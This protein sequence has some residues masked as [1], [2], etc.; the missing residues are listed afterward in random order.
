MMTSLIIIVNELIIFLTFNYNVRYKTTRHPL[1]MVGCLYMDVVSQV[2]TGHV[3]LRT[4]QNSRLLIL[5]VLVPHQTVKVMRVN[6][7]A[8]KTCF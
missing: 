6:V 1:D 2:E 3:L 8:W 5:M 7:L 4:T